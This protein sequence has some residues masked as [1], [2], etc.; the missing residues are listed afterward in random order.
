MSTSGFKYIKN[1]II[2]VDFDGTLCRNAWPEIGEPIQTVIDYI[3]GKQQLGAKIILWTNRTGKHLE[4]AT[5][6]CMD[7]GLVFDAINENLP[8]CIAEFGDDSRKIFA[9]SYI[10]DK[11]TNVLVIDAVRRIYNLKET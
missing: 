8:E 6:W 7:H 1:E 5:V 3:L 10:D 4:D 2:A 11:A 9:H